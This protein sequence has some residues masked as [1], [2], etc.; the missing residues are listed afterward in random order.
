MIFDEAMARKQRREFPALERQLN[1]RPA[2]FFDGPAGTQVPRAVAS[3]VASALLDYNANHG[4]CFATSVETDRM[5][6]TARE[7]MADLL[8]AEDPDCVIYGPNMTTLTMAF[9]RALSREW[10]AGDEVIV[11]AT[12]HDANI[13][14]WLLAAADR[15]VTVRWVDFDRTSYLLDLQQLAACLNSRTRLVC[16]GCASN[17][18]GG[19]NPIRE[20]VRMSHAAGAEVFLDAVHYGPH[21]LIDVVDWGC[22]WLVLSTYKF[23]GPHLGALWGKRGRLESIRPFK[24]RPSSDQLPWRWMTGTQSHEGIAGGLACIDYLAGIGRELAGDPGLNRREALRISMPAIQQYETG[25][26]WRLIDQLQTIDGI[27][28]HGITDRGMAAQRVSTVSFTMEGLPTPLL[29]QRL[30][31]EGIFC[32]GGNYYALEFTTRMGLEP[33][34]MIR[35]GLVHYNLP[36]EVDRLVA[37][38]Q[39]I[40]R[41][42]PTELV[43]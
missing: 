22:D 37:T 31:R 8:G 7:A 17:A 32:W 1:G 24:V 6:E 2:V 3:A 42:C 29:N 5:L 13:A 4:G 38:L 33:D 43:S 21:G 30:A 16:A 11:S 40:R 20:I 15:G 25:L 41:E 27:T 12:D 18:T 35:V 19:I 9:S 26:V 28:I 10:Q 14:P 36:E 34:G 39:A 23:F